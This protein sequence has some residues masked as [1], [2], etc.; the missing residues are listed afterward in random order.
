M[1]DWRILGAKVSRVAVEMF[2]HKDVTWSRKTS[3]GVFAAP[4]GIPGIFDSGF[5]E[6]RTAAGETTVGIA[7]TLE[8]HY[9]HFPDGVF[10]G[11]EDRIV[12]GT[13]PAAG[14]YVVHEHQPNEDRTGAVLQLV[15]R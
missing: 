15:K 9:G 7:P 4:V 13:G 1:A 14:N 5:A 12:V 8:I 6:L 2:D 3:E 11:V 10:P